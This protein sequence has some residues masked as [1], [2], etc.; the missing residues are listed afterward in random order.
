MSEPRL[1]RYARRALTIPS[2]VLGLLL[3]LALAP[4]AL[5]LAALVDR[6]QGKRTLPL[7]RLLAFFLS[8]LFTETYGLLELLLLWLR[9]L[10][11]R[12]ALARRTWPVQRRY[13][14]LHLFFVTRLYRLTFE[15]EGDE[16]ARPGPL[17]VFI[18]HSSIVDTLIPGGFLA[19][20]H[21]LELR[22]VLKKELLVDPC[23]DVAGQWLPNHFVARDGADTAKELDA[24]RALAQGLTSTDGVLLYP[25]G[26]RF[27][28]RKRE[29]ALERLKDDPAAHARASRLVHLLPPRPGGAL[30]LLDAAPTS[31]VL[32]VGHTGLEGFSDFKQIYSGDLVGR[33][34]RIRFWRERAASIPRTRDEQLAW[35]HEKWE[36]LDAWLTTTEPEAPALRPT[37]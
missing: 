37:G 35:L 3:A 6:L 34:V 33:T 10:G 7:T 15:V 13:V 16:L 14:A 32:F 24:I 19:N 17:L 8:F 31:D 11:Q 18:R 28:P 23:L 25:E 30:T 5:P 20:R 1:R 22:Y 2:V 4:L 9:C 26:T 27:T 12:E 21:L 29:R 36:R